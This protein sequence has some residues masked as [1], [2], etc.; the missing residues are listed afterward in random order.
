V[1]ASALAPRACGVVIVASGNVVHNLRRVD[2]NQ[3]DAGY[4]AGLAAA[5]GDTN[6]VLVGGRPAGQ[7]LAARTSTGLTSGGSASISAAWAASA[8]A[9][10]RW[11]DR[12]A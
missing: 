12:S 7:S 4:L 10:S 6:H 1:T 11:V 2:W 8:D 9:A 3:P 5:A